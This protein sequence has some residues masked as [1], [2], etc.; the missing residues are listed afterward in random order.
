MIAKFKLR[1]S[2]GQTEFRII[3]NV[4]EA[5]KQINFPEFD[6]KETFELTTKDQTFDIVISNEITEYNDSVPGAEGWDYRSNEIYLMND[7]GQTI[8]KFTGK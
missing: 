8:E 5:N 1:Y 2:E 3:D 6:G 4:L 7:N